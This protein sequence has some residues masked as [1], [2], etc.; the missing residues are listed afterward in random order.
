MRPPQCAAA[1]RVH[2]A[3]RRVTAFG[4]QVRAQ[5]RA[6]EPPRRRSTLARRA[7]AAGCRRFCCG[8]GIGSQSCALTAISPRQFPKGTA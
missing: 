4:L 3:A 7:R 6:E 2:A 1:Y 8:A 5:A